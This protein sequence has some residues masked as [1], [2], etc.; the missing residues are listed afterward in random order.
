MEVVI[1]PHYAS[2]YEGVIIRI[3]VVTQS[4]DHPPPHFDAVTIPITPF[5]E[6]KYKY[7][8]LKKGAAMMTT[9]LS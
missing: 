2:L 3:T 4:V 7:L 5:K 9:T 8:S 6:G 1:I